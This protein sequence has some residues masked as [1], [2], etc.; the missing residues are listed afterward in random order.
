MYQLG[1]RQNM[2]IGEFSKRTGFGI[3]TIRYYEKL[4]LLA[5]V[6][7]GNNRKEYTKKEED[8]ADMIKK[9]KAMNLSLQEIGVFLEADSSIIGPEELNEGNL[10]NLGECIRILGRINQELLQ[11]EKEI[12]ESRKLIDSLQV[13]LQKAYRLFE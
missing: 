13:K 4:G 8:I 2:R 5:P 6:R 1:D 3:D 7:Q 11:K 9:L 12:K 10:K